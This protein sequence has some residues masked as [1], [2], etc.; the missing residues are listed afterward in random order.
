MKSDRYAHNGQHKRRRSPHG[1]RG[2]KCSLPHKRQFRCKSLPSRGAWIEIKIIEDRVRSGDRSLPSRG[3]WIEMVYSPVS[4]P[5]WASLPS[6]GAWIEILSN[7]DA[8]LNE[9]SRSPHGERGLKSDRTAPPGRSRRGRSPH[10]ERGLKSPC[11]RQGEGHHPSLPS[12]GAW[13]EMSRDGLSSMVK[14]RSLPS[15]GAWIEI[16]RSAVPWGSFVVAPLTGSVD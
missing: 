9:G 6:R 1:E 15:R 10:G 7:G 13:I 4:P 8:Q 3:A 16:A 12:R 5:S 14:C 11:L 2:L